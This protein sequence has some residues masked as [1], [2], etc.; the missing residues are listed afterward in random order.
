MKELVE[1]VGPLTISSQDL[2]DEHWKK[3][4]EPCTGKQGYPSFI[5]DRGYKTAT[6]IPGLD[7]VIPAI[8]KGIWTT[9]IRKKN[10][11]T[12]KAVIDGVFHH[13]IS[14]DLLAFGINPSPSGY[15]CPQDPPDFF[16]IIKNKGYSTLQV[17]EL[18]KLL[19]KAK[20]YELRD[21]AKTKIQNMYTLGSQL[22]L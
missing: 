21:I 4:V 2:F 8:I 15:R 14:G 1:K 18:A 22:G 16:V 7:E 12:E 9:R 20:A 5:Y 10:Q 17:L 19:T 13:K 3:R 6:A 11:V